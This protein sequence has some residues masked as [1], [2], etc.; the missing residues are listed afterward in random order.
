VVPKP[1]ISYAREDQQTAVRLY[2]DLK[3]AGV[4]PWLDLAELL[5]GHEWA[6]EIRRAMRAASH[7][8]VLVSSHSVDKTGFVQNE[9]REALELAASRPAG[10][11]F[12]IPARL[13]ETT[14]K[15][16][17]LLQLHWVD[18]F[19][20]YRTGLPKIFAALG[21]SPPPEGPIAVVTEADHEQDDPTA[22]TI[23]DEIT[24]RHFI[25]TNRLALYLDHRIAGF[26]MSGALRELSPAALSAEVASLHVAGIQ[27]IEGLERELRANREFVLYWAEEWLGGETGPISLGA[28]ITYLGYIVICR[29]G[30]RSRLITFLEAA[31]ID[32]AEG[33]QA[34]ADNIM[35]AYADFAAGPT[36]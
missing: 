20:E 3:A 30:D 25:G 26:T 11:I 23:L 6:P 19:P 10:K 33:R 34:T 24:L 4:E 16:E 29:S 22:G 5:P 13:D 14:P 32:S 15:F 1:F 28:F 12:L 2:G 7:V 8:I 35:R 31:H 17:K 18:L 27:T 21:V 36:A 9:T